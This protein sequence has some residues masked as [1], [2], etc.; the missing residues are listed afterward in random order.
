ML[1]RSAVVAYPPTSLQVVNG[2]PTTADRS[3]IRSDLKVLRAHFDGLITYTATH[4]AEAIPG[5]AAS[6][7][8]RAVI[9]GIYD[10][11]DDAELDA[12]LEAARH[13]PQGVVGISLGN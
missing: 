9:I 8:Y 4:G 2:Q 7:G 6:L 1:E 12:A 11:F 13:Y 5:I 3:S 10:P